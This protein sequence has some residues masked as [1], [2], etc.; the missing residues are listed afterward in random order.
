MLNI[1]SVT[2]ANGRPSAAVAPRPGA[3]KRTGALR[4]GQMV[5]SNTKNPNFV[6]LVLAVENVAVFYDHLEYLRSFGTFYG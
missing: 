4:S 1:A 3:P 5:Y 6:L 2:P